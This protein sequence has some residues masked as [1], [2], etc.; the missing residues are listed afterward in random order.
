MDTKNLQQVSTLYLL[1]LYP[2]SSNDTSQTYLC[3]EILKEVTQMKEHFDIKETEFC[4]VSQK[5]IVE[6][7]RVKN[8]LEAFEYIVDLVKDSNL[9]SDFYHKASTYI[10]YASRKLKLSPLQT[11]L[12][13][14]FVD[15]SEDNSIRMSE[16]A[17]Y[18]GCRTT[19][20]LRLSSEIDAL[21]EKHYLRASRSRNCLSYRVPIEV[22]KT[23]RKNQPYIYV[24]EPITDL[25]SFFDRFNDLME[26]MNEDEITHETLLAQANENLSEI[27]STY[28]ARTLKGFNLGEE[29]CLLFIFMAHLFI[30]ND[31]N[32]IGFHDIDNL[33]DNDKIP[34]WCKSELRSRT[35]ELFERDLI[36]NVNEDGMARSDCFKLTEYAKT[37][38]LSELNL[39]IKTKSDH[40][41]IKSDSL[42]E[43]K[44]IYNLS[45]QKQV[46]E[47]SAILSSDR[48]NEVQSRLRN[49]GMRTGFCSLFY[50]SPGTGKTE[51]VYQ[52]ARVT[53]RDILRVDVDKIKSCW[54]GESEQNM[55]KLF[56]RYR[57]IC[58]DSTLAP[59]LL[60]NE[61][62]AILGVRM[63]GATRAVDKMENSIQNIILQEMEA[64]DGIM[65][66]TTNLTTNL[67]KAF[68][69][70]FLY[71]IQFNRP[72]VEA[73]AAI[74]QAMMPSLPE[75][76]A[77]TLASQ[78]DLSGGEIEN[79]I[80]KYTMEA[81]L[82]GQDSI[83]LSA[84]IELCRNERISNSTRVKI[85]FRA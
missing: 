20:M 56:D 25:Q 52:I 22:L 19:K 7:V 31:D 74:W 3:T 65:I 81:I 8:I 39:N 45:E 47:L 48:F 43:K 79:I 34:N 62:D 2:V 78:F 41:L 5:E 73:R 85:G 71:K 69:R 44:L 12:L 30:E 84:I 42:P 50:G 75:N 54:V 10:K 46:E 4:E 9:T 66:A 77:R 55:K 51:T 82:S 27:K 37:D 76:D 38:L 24:T 35:S 17:S 40:N 80:R 67:D 32:R 64:L 16:I 1:F 13:A 36:E 15:R 23:L 53:G 18:I 28:F 14:L 61:A 70:R 58:K 49:A 60:F 68:E 59:I 83:D 26:E 57:N 21:E 63:E 33:Y 11:V 72:T 6:K 29:D